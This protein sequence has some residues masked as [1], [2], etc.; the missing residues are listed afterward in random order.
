M[1]GGPRDVISPFPLAYF[2][3]QP[4]EKDGGA[5]MLRAVYH[6]ALEPLTP[7]AERGNARKAGY[8]SFATLSLIPSMQQ[9]DD[10]RSRIRSY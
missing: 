5:A 6:A 9:Q 1:W 7:R 3:K 2:A 10:A 4:T 8:L